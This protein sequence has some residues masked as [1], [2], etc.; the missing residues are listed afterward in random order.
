MRKKTWIIAAD[1]SRARIFEAIEPEQH[2][3]EIEDLANPEGRANNRELKSDAQGR[4]YGHG[5][6]PATHKIGRAHV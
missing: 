3:R 5:N 4:Y 1:S 2:L 6:R